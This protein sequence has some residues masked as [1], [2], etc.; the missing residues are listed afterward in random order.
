MRRFIIVGH[1]QKPQAPIP[2]SDPAGAGGRWDLLAR[3]VTSALLLSH[4]IRRDVEVVLV[5]TSARPPRILRVL[6]G[7][8]QRLNPDER[9][10]VAL[11]SK[12]LE[13][14]TVAGHEEAPLPGIRISRG[15]FQTVLTRARADGP[16]FWLDE[17]GEEDFLALP[18]GA[19]STFVLSDH[20]D[21]DPQEALELHRAGAR[22]V[23]LGPTILQSDQCIVVVNHRWDLGAPG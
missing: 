10:T 13:A 14:E 9:S 8:V 12:A 15:D 5:L 18:A 17:R 16:V 6:G 20:R 22:R 11:L 4:D 1:T 19:A 2:L 3:C 7:Q 23:H 21:F